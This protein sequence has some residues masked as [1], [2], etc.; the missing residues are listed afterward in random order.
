MNVSDK[1]APIEFKTI[2]LV[3][4]SINVSCRSCCTTIITSISGDLLNSVVLI[5]NIQKMLNCT[6]A[7]SFD[8]PTTSCKI[9]ATQNWF[10]VTT[11]AKKG[12][13]SKFKF[14]NFD[15]V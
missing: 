9:K 8:L 12:Y 2:L 10:Q 13:I 6:V 14:A 1:C 4:K 15:F 5:I 3:K 7:S 11:Y